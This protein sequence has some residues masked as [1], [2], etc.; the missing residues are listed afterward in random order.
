VSPA[1]TRF[2]AEGVM[3]CACTQLGAIESG[4]KLRFLPAISGIAKRSSES[5]TDR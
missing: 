1:G 2:I 3:H 4:K 5:T